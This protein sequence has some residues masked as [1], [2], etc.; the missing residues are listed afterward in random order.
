MI[1]DTNGVAPPPAAD[2]APLAP[3]SAHE[4][5][6]RTA[7]ELYRLPGSGGI[8]RLRR[9]S[10][11][12]LAAAGAVPNPLVEEILR[13]GVITAPDSAKASEADQ[14]AFYRRNQ[15][16]FIEVAR[17][18]LV[19]PVLITDRE[20]DPDR[21]E[22]GPDDLAER[23]YTW[24]FYGFVNGLDAQLEPFRV[25]RRVDSRRPARPT[26]PHDPSGSAGSD[27]A[28]SALAD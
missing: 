17:R 18:C 12:T 9:L 2:D 26:L 27:G 10:L 21:N 23:D 22:I 7:G 8:A 19:S 5:R 11:V 6:Q 24:L 4:W 1:A 20:P 16:A 13:L 25:R 28:T 3:T 14:M 15:K